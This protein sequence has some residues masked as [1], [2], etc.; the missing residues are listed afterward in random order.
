M[1]Y[2]EKLYLELLKQCLTYNIWGESFQTFE[3]TEL[4][5][6]KK[7][8]ANYFLKILGSDIKLVKSFKF[9]PEKRK[10]GLDWPPLAH[11]MV[12]LRRLDNI[13]FCVEDVIKR[14]VPG[15][16]IE[17]GVWRGGASIFMRGVLKAYNI[18]DKNVWLADSFEG[19]PPP[20]SEKY[21]NDRGDIHH[22]IKYLAVSME[23]VKTNF[24]KYDLLDDKIKF[25][26]GW[27]K[28]TL[29]NAPIDKLSVIRLDGDMYES[30]INS[31]ESL[32]PKLSK[33]GYLIVDDY[34][35]PNCRKAVHD[36]RKANNIKDEIVK[37]DS[38][39]VFW[40]RK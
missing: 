8:L 3:I 15:D 40:Q 32:Y 29:P 9:E 35:L 19:L 5:G 14:N 21:P 30:T 13:Q 39:G 23:E 16:L 12:G 28:D 33:G 2:S 27:F 37:I 11:T 26:K 4:K 34:A 25:L 24:E 20:N 18:L 36:Y 17:T 7:I 22:K 10:E 6:I 1:I 38:I 31:L